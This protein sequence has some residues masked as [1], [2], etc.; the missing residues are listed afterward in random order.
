MYITLMCQKILDFDM[1]LHENFYFSPWSFDSRFGQNYSSHTLNAA[2]QSMPRII[3]IL[4]YCIPWTL[5]ALK[6]WDSTCPETLHAPRH[7]MPWDIACPETMHAPRHSM[8]RDIACPKTLH[9][10]RH[11]IPWDIACTETLHI[12]SHFM[13]KIFH[14]MKH[15]MPWNI[16]LLPTK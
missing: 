5:H 1:F 8:P 11:T 16:V 3:R 6:L 15:S 9:A 10:P 14:A 13:P 2:R 7:C 4:G 12:L